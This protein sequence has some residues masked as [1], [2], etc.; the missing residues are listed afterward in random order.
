MVQALIQE[1][2]IHMTGRPGVIQAFMQYV[3]DMHPMA[4]RG[5]VDGLVSE[6]RKTT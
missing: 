6:T 1:A 5:F 4:Y 3:R 2:S